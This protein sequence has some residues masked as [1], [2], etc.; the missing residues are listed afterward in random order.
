LNQKLTE[1]VTVD[2]EVTG[3]IRDLVFFVKY[4]REQCRVGPIPEDAVLLQCAREFWD[5]EHG[6]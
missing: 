3:V 2:R 6:E 1:R 4:L 5:R